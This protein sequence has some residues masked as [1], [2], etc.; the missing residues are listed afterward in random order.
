MRPSIWLSSNKETRRSSERKTKAFDGLLQLMFSTRWSSHNRW[1]SD[2][3]NEKRVFAWVPF[4]TLLLS[5]RNTAWR[6]Q[7][8]HAIL[9]TI[10]TILFSFLR[11]TRTHVRAHAQVQWVVVI[12]GPMNILRLLLM[13]L[14]PMREKERGGKERKL[15]RSEYWPR[16][17]FHV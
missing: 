11:L 3:K 9:S 1:P 17:V 14:I 4:N 5:S 2:R 13:C 16:F 10:D 8:L 15:A 12:V 7:P 6:L